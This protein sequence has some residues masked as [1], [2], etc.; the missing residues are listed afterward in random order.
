MHDRPRRR[1]QAVAHDRPLP[2]WS[3][4]HRRPDDRLVHPEPRERRRT[5]DRGPHRPDV[6]SRQSLPAAV[7]ALPRRPRQEQPADRREDLP[8]LRPC[9][10]RRPTG[11]RCAGTRTVQGCGSTSARDTA[12]AS[13]RASVRARGGRRWRR[14]ASIRLRPS[15]ICWWAGCWSGCTRASAPTRRAI[16]RWPATEAPPGGMVR[17]LPCNGPSPVLHATNRATGP[18]C[19]VCG[20]RQ[21]VRHNPPFVTRPWTVT[22]AGRAKP[23]WRAARLRALRPA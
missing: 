15:D 2:H 7:R 3:Q 21:H 16:S 9:S 18:P 22:A 5:E 17:P 6:H 4:R 1:P 19:S 8:A 23:P 12:R 13:R 20:H 11:R 10:S 14:E